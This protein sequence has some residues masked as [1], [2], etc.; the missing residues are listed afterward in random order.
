MHLSTSNN[1]PCLLVC[2][3]VRHAPNPLCCSNSGSITIMHEL[4]KAVEDNHLN[5]QVLPSRCMMECEHGPNVKLNPVSRVW[6]KVTIQMIPEIIEACKK[7][8]NRY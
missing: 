5:I 4:Q 6:N 1:E 7:S 2:T 3:Q 8:L